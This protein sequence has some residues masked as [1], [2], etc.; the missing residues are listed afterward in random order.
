MIGLATHEPPLAPGSADD[1]RLAILEQHETIRSLLNAARTVAGLAAAGNARVADLLP[2]YLDRV[3]AALEQHLAFEDRL[4][5]PILVSDPPLG[6]ERA[7]RLREEH[8]RQRAE[9][10]ALA[11]PATDGTDLRRVTAARLRA[12]SEA[13][14]ADMDEEERL[15]LTPDVLRDD[16]VS[17]DQD[18][19]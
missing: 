2:T 12:L 15:L 5:I 4:L 8:G 19:G 7:R 14:L 13:F 1:A 9:L 17:V 6:P 11:R 10:C 3:R 16:L 18:A